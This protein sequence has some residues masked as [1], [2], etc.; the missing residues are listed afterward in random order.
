MGI[1]LYIQ[2]TGNILMYA[3][4]NNDIEY[5]DDYGDIDVF[6]IY[7]N[8]KFDTKATLNSTKIMRNSLKLLPKL[9]GIVL[10]RR[11]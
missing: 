8:N 3:F 6:H 2:C 11:S 4:N 1:L 7:N 9:N 5:Y 10:K